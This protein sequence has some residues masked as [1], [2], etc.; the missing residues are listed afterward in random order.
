MIR[1]DNGPEFISYQLDA[2]SKRNQI[3]LVFIQTWKP[4]QNGYIGRLNG[5]VRIEQ[6]NAYVLNTLTE[7]R[8]KVSEWAED[9]NLHRPHKA[10]GYTSPI[11][12]REQQKID[13]RKLKKL[14]FEWHEKEG[15]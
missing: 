12:F 1:V 11:V 10:L 2:W 14:T 6:L 7:V 8:S 4:M 9:Y 13:D 5:S 15:S 3:T